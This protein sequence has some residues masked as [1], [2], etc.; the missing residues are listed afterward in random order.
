MGRLRR[1][2]SSLEDLSAELGPAPF[3]SDLTRTDLP[4]ALGSAAFKWQRLIT[5]HTVQDHSARGVGIKAMLGNQVGGILHD[6]VGILHH[7]E[8]FVVI[9][10]SEPHA[11]TDDL[12]D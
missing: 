3:G 11:C 4:R 7:L 2:R 9:I 6:G 1:G 10:L 8:V 12:E 5:E